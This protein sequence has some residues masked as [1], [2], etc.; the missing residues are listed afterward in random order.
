MDAAHAPTTL[1]E[2]DSG[3]HADC[4]ESCPIE[5]LEDVMAVGTYHLSKHEGLPDTRSGTVSLHHLGHAGQT[6]ADGARTNVQSGVFDMKWSFQPVHGKALMGLVTA[7]GT[8]EIVELNRDTR[9]LVPVATTEGSDAMFLSLDWNNRVTPAADP[10]IAVS[11]TNGTVSIWQHGPAALEQIQEWRAHD[12]FGSEIEVW[13]T[14][15]NYHNTNVLYT[16]GDD[17]TF[18]G[19]D[20]RAAERPTF[21][22]RDIHTMGVCSIHTHPHDEH[23]V[24]VGSYDETIT[25]W[26]VRNFKQPTTQYSTGGGV[27]RL[28]WHPLASHKSLLLA[29]CM[30]NGFQI[31]DV[32]TP[33]PTV[34]AHYTKQTSL[35]YGVDWWHNPTIVASDTPVVGSASFYDHAFHVWHATL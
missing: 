21:L 4:V 10:L 27:W 8:L 32:S 2:R 14:A 3:L 20:V 31:L 34:R 25:L 29:A 23:V 16:G 19:W 22:K 30:H 11:Q 9:E 33:E 15:W 12:L 13:I 6:M 1:H 35:A 18:K 28:K 26:D 17:A 7:V 5:G 24:A